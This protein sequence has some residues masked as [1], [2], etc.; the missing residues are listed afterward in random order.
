[1]TYFLSN[2][3]QQMADHGLNILDILIHFVPELQEQ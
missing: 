1:M 2:H 3:Q